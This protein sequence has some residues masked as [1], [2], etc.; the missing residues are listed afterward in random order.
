MPSDEGGPLG[1]SVVIPCRDAAAHLREA[2]AAL[3]NEQPQ[4]PWEVIVVDNGSRDGT[5]HVATEFQDLLPL[6]VVDAGDGRGA[7]Y[8]RNAGAAEARGELLVFLDSDDVVA[9]GYLTR[10]QRALSD[11]D[12]VAAQPEVDQLNPGWVARSRPLGLEKGLNHGLGFLPFAMSS[13]LGIRRSAFESLEGFAAMTCEDIDL[14]WRAQLLGLT[15]TAAPGAVLHY[16]LRSTRRAIFRQAVGYGLSMPL[17]YRRF[18][19]AGMPPR[20]LGQAY[21]DWRVAARRLLR[22]GDRAQFG[23]GV[24]L[25]GLAVG[26]ALGSV[27]HRSLYF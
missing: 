7:G 25:T 5:R 9:S 1:L 11:S 18:R 4:E 13:C 8:A 14:S 12:L 20:G 23:E 24:Y 3:A 10:M 26:R 15:L 19:A 17:L 2:L 6:R 22:P 27:R 21:R 16:R